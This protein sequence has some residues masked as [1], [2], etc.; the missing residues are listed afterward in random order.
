MGPS[1]VEKITS[2]RKLT[3]TDPWQK[4]PLRIEFRV[5]SLVRIAFTQK[6]YKW[7]QGFERDGI[8]VEREQRSLELEGGHEPWLSNRLKRGTN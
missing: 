2:A 8:S 4:Q 7:R 1:N 3:R 5:P 6:R